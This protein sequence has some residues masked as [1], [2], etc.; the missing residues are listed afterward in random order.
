SQGAFTRAD[1]SEFANWILKVSADAVDVELAVNAV[2]IENVYNSCSTLM[3][4]KM[5][6]HIWGWIQKDPAMTFIGYVSGENQAK[7]INEAIRKNIRLGKSK[8]AHFND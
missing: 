3:L 7:R 6:L 4:V 1:V 8:E 2:T 5:P